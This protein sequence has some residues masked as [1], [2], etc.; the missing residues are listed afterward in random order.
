MSEPA[1]LD[2]RPAAGRSAAEVALGVAPVLNLARREVA[3][4]RVAAEVRLPDAGRPAGPADYPRFTDEVAA[5]VDRRRLERAARLLG[6]GGRTLVLPQAFR[7]LAVRRGRE[8]I[9]AVAPPDVLKRSLMI[10]LVDVT[11]G[12]PRGRLIEV[13][14][15]LGEICGGVLVRL[16][17]ARDAA[18]PVRGVRLRGV[19]VDASEF[20]GGESRLVAGLLDFCSQ[21]KGAAPIQ[22]VYGLTDETHLDIAAVAGFTHGALAWRDG[23]TR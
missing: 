13:V 23:A 10:E 5:L 9:Q 16:S 17:P 7:T 12:T 22:L 20:S 18:A 4:H 8:A 1:A 19:T 6:G 3:A 15:L 2:T 11:L 21:L 14:G